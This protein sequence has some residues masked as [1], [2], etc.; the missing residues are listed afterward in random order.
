MPLSNAEYAAFRVQ[1][2]QKGLS[3]RGCPGSIVITCTAGV[4]TALWK[5]DA[6]VV[7]S[8]RGDDPVDTVDALFDWIYQF[9]HDF[10]SCSEDNDE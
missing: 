8:M 1:M 10:Y 6:G 4:S 9:F 2:I 3:L 5:T 7:V